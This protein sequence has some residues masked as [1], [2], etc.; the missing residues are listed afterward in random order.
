MPVLMYSFGILKWTQTEL[1][2]LD[3]RVRTLLT[4]N[5]MH[6]PRSSI[7]RLYIP[8]KCGGRG[9]LNAKTLHNREVCNLREYFLKVNEG[10][11][12]EV[13]A[14]DNGF[15][16]LSLAKE[17]WRKPV[18]LSVNDRKEVWHS[19]ELHGRFFRALHGPS[20]DFLASVSWL[21][22]S[23][24]FGETEG[25][26][27]A[28]MDEVI[29]T[30]NYRKYIIKDGT[31]DICR[32][33]H[34]PGESIR[35]IISGCG[36]LANGEYLH[37]HN[38]VAKIIHQ[39]LALHYQL[40]EFEVPYYKYV[41]DPVLE[42]GHITLYW[43]RSI[44]TDRTIVANKPDIVVIDRQARRAMIVDITIPHDE[45][46]VKAE[47]DKQIKYLDLA[48]EV[49]DMWSVDS[50]IIV[51]IVVSANGLIPNSLD[52]HLRRLGLGGWIKGLMQKAVLL[53]TAR[54]VRRFLSLEP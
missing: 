20:V 31:V 42:N 29:L 44:I 48:H 45:N 1:N 27:C 51:P 50:A 30:N 16:P 21:R 28:I 35:H 41:P 23:N 6:H 10:M 17:N 9:L 2:A 8:R 47:K 32:A 38:Q 43:D 36:R 40:V 15:T 46:L 3:R 14:V 53:E 49:V 37:R 22:F 18:V 12:R 4:A 24:L 34:S 11:H 13:A 26:V 7:M 52:N 39:R 54:I 25:F 33:C 19:K 5:R